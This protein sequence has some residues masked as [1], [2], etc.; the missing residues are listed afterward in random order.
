VRLKV[1]QPA[2]GLVVRMQLIEPGGVNYLTED[3]LKPKPGEAVEWVVP[4]REFGHGGFSSPDPN[5]RL[6]LDRIERLLVGFNQKGDRAVVEI[7][8]IEAVGTKR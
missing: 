1:V 6:D 7:L 3:G 5:G 4:F 8:A 2:E